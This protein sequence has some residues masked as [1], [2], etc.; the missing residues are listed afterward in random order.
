MKHSMNNDNKQEE[1]KIR[2]V[3][4]VNNDYFI[5]SYGT[6]NTYTANLPEKYRNQVRI[7]DPSQRV[8]YVNPNCS[9]D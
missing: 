4:E 2:R 5:G 3:N 9:F 7:P 1:I 6:P 8:A